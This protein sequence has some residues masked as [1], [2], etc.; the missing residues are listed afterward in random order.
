[1]SSWFPFEYRDVAAWREDGLPLST[2]SNEAAK[3]LDAA[4]AQFALMDADSNEG[5]LMASMT[6]VTEAD[7][8][9]NMAK[10]LMLQL[11]AQGKI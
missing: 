8:D 3:H 1:M 5:G 2:P 9:C 6:K 7:P 11:Q 4:I 10:I